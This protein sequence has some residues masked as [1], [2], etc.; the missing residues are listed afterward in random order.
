MII[1][2]I[3]VFKYKFCVNESLRAVYEGAEAIDTSLFY[4]T[5]IISITHTGMAGHYASNCHIYR[6][7][8]YTAYST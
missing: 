1:L 3:I 7:L 5:Q 6:D 2:R 8:G 4:H